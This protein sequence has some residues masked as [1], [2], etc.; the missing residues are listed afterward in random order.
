MDNILSYYYN[1][2][3][4][5][6]SHVKDKYFF[7]Y[8]DRNYIF[9]KF[10][11][12]ITDIDALYNINKKMIDKNILVHEIILNSEGKIISYV[13]NSPYV[14]LEYFVNINKKIT[15]PEVC[16]INNNSI[17]IPCDKQLYRN[18]WVNLWEAKNDYFEVQINEI[19]RRFPYLCIYA[20][21]Y[22]GLAENAIC[23]V[24][25]VLKIDD[26]ALFSINHK[27]INTNGTLYNLYHPFNFIYDYRIRDVCEYI[28]SCFFNDGDPYSEIQMFFLNNYLSYKE[29]LLFYGRLFYPSYFFDLYDDIVNENLNEEEINNIIIKQEEYED[30][31][32]WV[33]NYLSNL[34]NRY[35][36][37][38]D[39]IMK[40]KY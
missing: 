37:P 25:N 31:L 4:S 23:Y 8:Q 34:Y 3:P 12:P 2:H 5:E 13:N 32:V 21:Y 28:K 17:N 1:I 39:W 35:I 38:V 24:K 15:L 40:R 27:R 9:E 26:D 29:V 16:Y 18:D 19:S 6:I 36:P 22:I 33:Y 7:S 11:R 20:N 30:F 10:T 14:L